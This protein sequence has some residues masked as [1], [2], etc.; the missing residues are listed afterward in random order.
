[1]PAYRADPGHFGMQM[2]VFGRMR[3]T[4]REFAQRA[5]EVLP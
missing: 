3:E 4:E 5:K 2:D 1:V